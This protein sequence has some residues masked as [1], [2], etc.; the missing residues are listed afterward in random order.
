MNEHWAIVP[1]IDN[2]E[3]TLQAVEDLLAQTLPCRVLLVDQGSSQESREQVDQYIDQRGDHR[4]LCWHCNPAYPSLSAAWNRALRMVWEL[5]GTEALVVNNDVRLHAL[6]YGIL[7]MNMHRTDALFVSAVGVREEQFT[8]WCAEGDTFTDETISGVGAND[9]G[10]PDFSC[11]LLSKAGHEKYPF[12]ESFQPCYG[13]DCSAHREYMLG[14]DGPRIFSVNLPFLHYASGTLKSYTP[15]QRAKFDRQYAGV[16]ATYTRHW[17]G[18]PNQERF[19]AKDDPASARE[20]VTNPEL[21]RR[22]QAGE[23]VGIMEVVK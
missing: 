21:Q 3:M 22:V 2:V 9:K 7:R 11:F 16:M 18:P 6:T 19:M 1:W 14:G 12:D 5:G 23:S 8:K 13:E 15:E 10:G 20:G 17:G 4:V